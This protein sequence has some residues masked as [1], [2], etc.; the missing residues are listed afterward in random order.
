MGKFS[1]TKQVADTKNYMGEKAYTRSPKAELV[2]AV[3]TS[4][5]ETTYYEKADKR[6]TRISE[7]VEKVAAKDPVFVAKLAI[8]ARDNFNM[9][10]S[11][12]VLI[13]EL[14]RVHRGDNLVGRAL[15]RV[16]LRP[17]DVIEI[18]AY[19]DKP[20]PS[21]IKRGAA[22]ALSGYSEYQL[23]KYRGGSKKMKLVDVVNLVRP[24]HTDGLRK[25][26]NG[27]LKN[28][29]TW[30]SMLSVPGADKAAV[31]RELLE[32]HKLGYMA[33]L[34]NLR[35]IAATNDTEA[36]RLAVARIR[37]PEAVRKSRQFPFRFLSAY[38]ALSGVATHSGIHF[39]KGAGSTDELIAAVEDAIRLSVGNLPL[40]RGT[41]AILS[42]NSGSMR[43][44][45]RGSALSA[46]SSRKTSDIANLFAALYWLR[47][48][49]TYVGL[50]GDELI[51][52]SMDRSAGVF[53]NYKI[54]EE[55]ASHCGPGTEQGI[56]D[57]FEQAL[58]DRTMI[59]RVF[60][61]SDMQIGKNSWYGHRV[62]TARTFNQLF[63]EYKEINPGVKVYSVDLRGYGSTVFSDGIIEFAGFSDKIFNIVELTEQ[64]PNALTRQ[65]EAIE[66]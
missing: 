46:N 57:F 61:F 19:V 12:H 23:A 2:N 59:D 1:T 6:L 25:L 53:E 41:T 44:D 36:V 37:D 21:Q 54:I 47:A 20:L 65:I 55:A 27:E 5:I 15:Q 40:L 16:A 35:N 52:P 7:L 39:E 10:S 33:L 3:L 8:F 64:D 31:W 51:A 38:E 42:D 22:R 66:L 24:K 62:G 4:F 43:G 58:R 50:F 30:E 63:R 18:V 17:D 48:D 14:A 13:G 28:T 32:S 60:I 34:R 11:S 29:E 45:S 9:R 26:V 49:N 56:Y